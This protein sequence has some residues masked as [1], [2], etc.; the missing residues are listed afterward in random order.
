MEFSVKIGPAYSS[1]EPPPSV[2]FAEPLKYVAK[3]FEVGGPLGYREQAHE[4]STWTFDKEDRLLIQT[5][6]LQVVTDALL[7]EGHEV[8]QKDF[9]KPSNRLKPDEDVVALTRGEDRTMVRAIEG[10]YR[11]QVEVRSFNQTVAALLLIVRLFPKARIL[12]LVPTNSMARNLVHHLKPELGGRIRRRRP[13]EKPAAKGCLVSTFA[14]FRFWSQ[15]YPDEGEP[16]RNWDL[17][18]LPDPLRS[19]G[20]VALAALVRFSF[21]A[22]RLYSFIQPQAALSQRERVQL[23]AVSGPLIYRVPKVRVGTQ[24]LWVDVPN[25]GVVR[26]TSP[27]EWKREAYW[28]NTCRNE[29]VAAVAR[30][31]SRGDVGKLR[32]LG[33]RVEGGVPDTRG[34]KSPVVAVLVESSEHGRELQKLLGWPVFSYPSSTSETQQE[35]TPGVIVTA[36]RAERRGLTPDVMVVASG[37]PALLNL[38]RAW[39]KTTEFDD[40]EVLVVDFRDG[41]DAKMKSAADDRAK[42]SEQRGWMSYRVAENPA[43]VTSIN[44]TN[45]N[46]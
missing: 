25:C 26:W 44:L 42:D 37:S 4:Y 17:I 6:A 33:V 11:G 16:D 31:F 35:R 30:A 7:A 8:K 2:K 13:N 18:L 27:L 40:S 1:I 22:C 19:L 14:L 12:I 29:F 24:L 36:T 32:K 38:E 41:Y 15:H 3:D 46:K 39:P 10:C 20:K 45:S 23:T 34:G 5:P 43:K 9:R 28:H 21:L